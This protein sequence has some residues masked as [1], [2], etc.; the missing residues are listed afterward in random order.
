MQAFD[1]FGSIHQ[2]RQAYWLLLILLCSKKPN[3]TR[4]LLYMLPLHPFQA[5]P[6]NKHTDAHNSD[7][8]VQMQLNAQL[9]DSCIVLPSN[10]CTPQQY[11]HEVFSAMITAL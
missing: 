1:T 11:M 2:Q 5:G 7:S 10:M 4:Y 9:Y 8:S 3:A 6:C